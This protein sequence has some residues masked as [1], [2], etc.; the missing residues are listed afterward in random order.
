MATIYC[1][2]DDDGIRELIT[3]AL[4]TGGYEV[5]SFAGV[6]RFFKYFNLTR[7]SIDSIFIIRL[8]FKVF[9]ICQ[10]TLHKIFI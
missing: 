2:E 10:N 1:V 6:H 5:S 7:Q 3:C 9:I 8:Q 4:K